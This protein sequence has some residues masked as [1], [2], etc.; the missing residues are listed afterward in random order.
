MDR[1]DLLLALAASRLWTAALPAAAPVST[2]AIVFDAYGTL[3]DV[4]SVIQL[5]NDMFPGQ[6]EALSQRWRAKQ[7]EYSWTLSLMGR[8]DDFWSVTDHALV[9]ACRALKLECSAAQHQRLMDSYLRLSAFPDAVEGLKALSGRPL[10]IL[11][12]GTPKMLSAVVSSAGLE[13]VFKTVISVD[14]IR[15][16]KPN[17]RVYRLA[18]D[19]L[20]VAAASV[21]FVSSNFWDAEG[22]KAF[23]F[24]TAW[25]NRDGSPQDELSLAPD[26]VVTS[27]GE[28]AGRL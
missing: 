24:R 1:R 28:L 13:G 16:Y 9:F 7:L 26:L 22:A 8:Y 5:A 12:N 11:S 2:Q 3:L 19:A 20:H 14:R 4:H 21:L 23:G 6:G 10:A 17:P 15:I 27:L 25:I 18:V